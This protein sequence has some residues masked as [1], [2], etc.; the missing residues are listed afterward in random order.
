MRF[1]VLILLQSLKCVLIGRTSL[2][3][4]LNRIP[5]LVSHLKMSHDALIFLWN[6]LSADTRV[7]SY[8]FFCAQVEAWPA[9]I[10]SLTEWATGRA[11]ARPGKFQGKVKRRTIIGI[12]SALRSVHVVRQYA[13][14]PFESH[15][16]KR[17]VDGIKRC[18]PDSNTQKAEPIFHQS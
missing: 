10:Q 15:W 4:P 14:T 1:P 11:T 2:F 7:K 3:Q 8:E 16:L 18:Q 6:G 5:G 13:L 17:L 12:F 9:S